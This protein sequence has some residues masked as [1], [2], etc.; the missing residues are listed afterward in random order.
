M[1]NYGVPSWFTDK[2]DVN[3][4]IHAANEFP[5]IPSGTK[6]QPFCY[7]CTTLYVAMNDMNYTV[8]GI[9]PGEGFSLCYPVLRFHNVW[10]MFRLCSW[11][12]IFCMLATYNGM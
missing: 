9:I 3:Y 6:L 10:M 7:N 8:E 1:R 11:G 4:S 5:R 2:S 12:H